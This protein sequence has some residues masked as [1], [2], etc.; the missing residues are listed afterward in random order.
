MHLHEAVEALSLSP[1]QYYIAR[2]SWP[3][4]YVVYFYKSLVAQ[5]LND[6]N[7]ATVC[8]DEATLI[9]CSLLNTFRDKYKPT[10]DDILAKDRVIYDK[11]EMNSKYELE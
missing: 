5:L 7:H 4:D 3:E 6:K 2:Q 8:N 1:R 9:K 11:D 10:I